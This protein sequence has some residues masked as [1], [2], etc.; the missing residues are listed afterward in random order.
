MRVTYE[1][2]KAMARFVGVAIALCLSCYSATTLA[3][4]G[5]P[6]GDWQH[7]GFIMDPPVFEEFLGP[8]MRVRTGKSSYS[9]T[10]FLIW[11][12]A[13]FQEAQKLG[14]KTYSVEY[15]LIELDCH[16][17]TF[18]DVRDVK[19]DSADHLVSD[20][21]F[22]DASRKHFDFNFTGDVGTLP[23]DEDFAV[24]TISFGGCGDE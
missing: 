8:S 10:A 20:V 18:K 17:H 19:Y 24:T 22:K 11:G 4:D 23:L 2:A 9:K 15:V 21:V 13:V 6:D 3:K 12:K 14:A 7:I 5:I 16:D 1:R